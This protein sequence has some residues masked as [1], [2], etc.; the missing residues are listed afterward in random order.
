MRC[1]RCA[2][3]TGSGGGA[4]AGAEAEDD[5]VRAHVPV[6][7]PCARSLW[8]CMHPRRAAS[9]LLRASLAV[10]HASETRVHVCGPPSPDGSIWCLRSLKYAVYVTVPL[11]Y[12]LLVCIF[13]RGVTLPGAMTGPFPF[14]PITATVCPP[15]PADLAVASC[16]ALEKLCTC[17]NPSHPAVLAAV[18]C[19]RPPGDDRDMWQVWSTTSS[20]TCLASSS[21]TPTPTRGRPHEPLLSGSPL[22]RASHAC[23]DPRSARA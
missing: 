21:T 13:I 17:I 16:L 6:Q 9:L 2:L 23:G 3:R 4:G 18:G 8:R 22:V 14:L 10:L 12:F 20:P 11:P 7:A 15:L 19:R 5:N 1:L